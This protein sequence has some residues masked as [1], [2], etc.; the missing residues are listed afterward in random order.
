MI[1]WEL[2]RGYYS[3]MGIDVAEISC[4]TKLG[5]PPVKEWVGLKQVHSAVVHPGLPP[6]GTPGDGWIVSRPGQTGGIKVA[7]CCPVFLVDRERGVVA[8]VH[9]GW[10]GALLGVHLNALQ[11]MREIHGSSP[12]GIIAAAG[13]C[14]CGKCYRVGEDVA[15]RF[16]GFVRPSGRSWTLDIFG[17]V[18]HTLRSEGVLPENIIAPPACTFEA[19]H[20]WSARRDGFKGRIW[21][22]ARLKGL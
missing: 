16:S 12:A 20:L 2:S 14:I 7:D 13:P 6:Q 5:F 3:L 4:S 22:F 18:A 8:G 17:F 1:A 9:A 15:K 10:R 21:C 11:L 19:Q